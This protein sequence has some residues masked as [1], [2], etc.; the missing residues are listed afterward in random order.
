LERWLSDNNIPYPSPA[1]RKDLEKLVS[2]N[3]NDHAVAPYHSWD[4]EKL[5]SYLKQKGVE[6]KDTAADN[7]DSLIAQVK[8]YWYESEDKAQHAWL[9]TRDWILDSWTDSQ[10]KS[11]CDRHGIPG[12]SMV[13][14]QAAS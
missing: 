8:N 9:N 2:N 10:L 4:A 5:S 14:S 6:T 12:K 13:N 7:K 11:F 1:D 3:W